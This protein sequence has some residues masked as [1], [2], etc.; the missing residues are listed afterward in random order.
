METLIHIT[1][2]EERM[3]TPAQS[4]CNICSTLTGDISFTHYL[5][6]VCNSK[7]WIPLC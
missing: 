3:T 5:G 1:P 2:E 7:H 4:K 6:Y